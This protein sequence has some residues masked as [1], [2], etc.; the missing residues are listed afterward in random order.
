MFINTAVYYSPYIIIYKLTKGVPAS[1]PLVYPP[2]LLLTNLFPLPFTL[3]HL[4][5]YYTSLNNLIY[6]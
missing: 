2:S 4:Y 6:T 3:P 5:I 1:T